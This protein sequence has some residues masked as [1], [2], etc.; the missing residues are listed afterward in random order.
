MDGPVRR[1][2]PP[3]T[4]GRALDFPEF[5]PNLLATIREGYGAS[6]FRQDA[7]AG[8]TVAVVALPLSIA[9]AIASGLSPDKGLIAAIVGG[10]VISAFG[11]SRFQIGGPAGAFIVLVATIVE[12]RGTGGL[13]LAMM[14]AGVLM[15]AL[16][17]TRLGSLVR[18]VPETVLTGFTTGIAVIIAASQLKEL[19]GLDLIKEPSALLPKLQALGAAVGTAKPATVALSAA[20]VGVILAC[21][22]LAPKWPAFLIGVV[23]ATLAAQLPGLDVATIGSKFG[24][25]PDRIPAP[26]LPLITAAKLQAALLDAVAIA[27][28]GSIES[29]LSAAVADNMTG[30]T[31]PATRHRS[32]MEL[33]AQGLANIVTALFGGMVVTGTL[34]RT[35]TSIKAGAHG[36]VAGMLHALFLLLFVLFAAHVASYAPLAALAAVLAVVCWGMADLPEFTKVFRRAGPDALVVAVTFLIT[37]FVDLILAI[38]V[39]CAV[40]FMLRRWRSA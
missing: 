24:D 13:F 22:R 36:P 9:I 16:G 30:S 18:H 33:V 11:G 4:T 3:L 23:A 28:L 34:A 17:A 19:F 27:L 21:R 8:L 37:I 15:I 14:M 7:V 25:L 40:A 29:L 12:Q 20:T 10:V 38:A 26:A 31:S 2:R 32:N 39:G 1:A 6:E 35:A 5:T